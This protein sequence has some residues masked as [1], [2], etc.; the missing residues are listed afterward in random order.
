MSQKNKH[1]AVRHQVGSKQP[2]KPTK[3]LHA[4]EAPAFSD[5]V[6]LPRLLEQVATNVGVDSAMRAICEKVHSG[7]LRL[8][9]CWTQGPPHHGSLYMGCR[10]SE[11]L[12]RKYE[13]AQ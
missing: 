6:S 3:K 1:R 7:K 13:S 10:R 2:T 12:P 11:T 5:M 4:K 8:W 9:R